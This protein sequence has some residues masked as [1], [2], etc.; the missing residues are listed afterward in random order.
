[1]P[2]MDGFEAS[3]HIRQ[4]LL[5]KGIRVPTIVALTG[6]VE[7]EFKQKAYESGIEQVF[8]KP[9]SKEKL[10]ALLLSENF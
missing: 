9:F 8:S 7:E 4:L 5:S 10:A 6:H 2:E 1:M 3:K